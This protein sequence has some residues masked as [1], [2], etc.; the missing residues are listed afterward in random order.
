MYP[1]IEIFG[2]TIHTYGLCVLVGGILGILIA[3][4]AGKKYGLTKLDIL[5]FGMYAIIAGFIGAKL[6]YIIV[7]WDSVWQHPEACLLY[8]SFTVPMLR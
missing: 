2:I 5:L 3:M 4:W 8:T 6:L 1:A 7:E